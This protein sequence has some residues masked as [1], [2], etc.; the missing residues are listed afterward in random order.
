MTVGFV[1]FS[2][3]THTLLLSVEEVKSAVTELVL[4]ILDNDPPQYHDA[5]KALEDTLKELGMFSN[6]IQVYIKENIPSPPTPPEEIARRAAVAAEMA[7]LEAEEEERARMKALKAADPK[8]YEKEMRLMMAEL[9]ESDPEAYAAEM[10][11]NPGGFLK[12]VAKNLPLFFR[13]QQVVFSSERGHGLEEGLW[14]AWPGH[15]EVPGGQHCDWHGQQE[16]KLLRGWH[17]K[18]GHRGHGD[19][20]P[21]PQGCHEGGPGGGFRRR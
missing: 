5:V 12:S 6:D 13:I 15:L 8:A 18:E 14:S 4:K 16:G 3:N 20:R 21:R 2:D 19:R 1:L 7:R 17:H 9:K 11:K 10:K